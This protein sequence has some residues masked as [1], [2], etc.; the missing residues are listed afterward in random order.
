M[1]R[2]NGGAA[3]TDRRMIFYYTW[4]LGNGGYYDEDI[5]VDP[6]GIHAG[7]PDLFIFGHGRAFFIEMKR[8]GQSATKIQQLFKKRAE[9]SI[10]VFQ[11]S[12]EEELEKLLREIEES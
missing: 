1:V 3:K 2:I 11:I 4:S 7:V 6:K 8:P 10:D 9:G 12:S 5:D